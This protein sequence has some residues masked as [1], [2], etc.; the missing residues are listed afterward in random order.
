MAS[1]DWVKTAAKRDEKH[2]R[3]GIWCV[4][5]YKMDGKWTLNDLQHEHTGAFI[6]ELCVSYSLAA[7]S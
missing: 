6:I 3:F 4:L 7:V 1:M 2:L 5:Y